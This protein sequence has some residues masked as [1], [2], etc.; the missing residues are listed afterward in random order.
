M[1]VTV[2]ASQPLR[3]TLVQHLLNSAN[4]GHTSISSS[5][6]GLFSDAQGGTA[7]LADV[8]RVR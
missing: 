5:L 6:E 8:L 1:E 2:L 4:N 3:L 7:I